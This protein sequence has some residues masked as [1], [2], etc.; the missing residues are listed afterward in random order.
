M[1]SDKLHFLT[2]RLHELC[3]HHSKKGTIAPPKWAASD[4]A[5]KRGAELAQIVIDALR[6]QLGE[7]LKNIEVDK[8]RVA[9]DIESMLEKSAKEYVKA[10]Q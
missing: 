9:E 2:Y 3:W 5:P 8:H 6:E 4:S 1:A 7:T 10:I